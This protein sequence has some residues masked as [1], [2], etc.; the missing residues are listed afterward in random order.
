MATIYP[1]I[2]MKGYTR[3]SV[4]VKGRM[5]GQVRPFVRSCLPDQLNRTIGMVALTAA[6]AGAELTMRRDSAD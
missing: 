3:K 6:Q 5:V 1:L 4:R 2:R